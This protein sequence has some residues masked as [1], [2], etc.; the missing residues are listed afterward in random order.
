MLWYAYHQ[1]KQNLPREN[2]PKLES[3]RQFDGFLLIFQP[4]HPLPRI[5][6][7]GEA[8][9]GGVPKGDFAQWYE[10][11]GDRSLTKPA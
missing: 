5:R 10:A 6:H 1:N 2:M 11:Q 9:V 3:L 4:R 7:L 8:G